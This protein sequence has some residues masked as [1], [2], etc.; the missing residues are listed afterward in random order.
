MRS[1]GLKNEIFKSPA[2][3][4]KSH[5]IKYISSTSI[6][7]NLVYFLSSMYIDIPAKKIKLTNSLFRTISG[8]KV[9]LWLLEL[10][11]SCAEPEADDGGGCCL[12]RAATAAAA[13]AA[14]AALAAA[15]SLLWACSCSALAARVALAKS[16]EDV[17]LPPIG[18][19][20]KIFN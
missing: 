16:S 1:G 12:D 7:R 8:G 6:S 19:K 3:P 9:G 15:A 20:S 14:A 17:P 13:A 11:C 10:D 18:G 4:T 5:E 2:R